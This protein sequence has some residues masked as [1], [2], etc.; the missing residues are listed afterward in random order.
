MKRLPWIVSGGTLLCAVGAIFIVP[1]SRY[2]L[3]GT[4]R[5]EPQVN[6]KHVSYWVHALDSDDK[7]TRLQAAI[8]L[9]NTGYT[10]RSALPDLLRVLE[11]DPDD[12]TRAQAAFA[13]YKISSDVKFHGDHATEILDG[14]IRA[15]SDSDP[16]ARMN[17]ALAL[18]TLGPDAAKALPEL[19]EQIR[20]GDNSGHLLESPM[21]I[22]DHMVIAI[23][24]VGPAAKGNVVLLE[25]LLHHEDESTRI[26][27]VRA[28]GLLGPDA[29][30]AVPFLVEVIRD[31]NELLHVQ[32]KARQVLK[33]IDPE[34]AAKLPKD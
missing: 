32:Q 14:M 6:G 20:H 25:E 27:A 22:R 29:K 12:Y 23:G 15:L 11:D 9:S 2:F 7:D 19:E 26:T 30:H 34:A 8:N 17:A 13:I 24:H 33:L 18:G 3:F 16:L 1:S 5:G 10:G 28:L 4:V 21:S 31:P